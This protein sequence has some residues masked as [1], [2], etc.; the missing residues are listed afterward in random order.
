VFA[1]L[2]AL[3]GIEGRLF[4]PLGVA[5]LVSIF[6]SMVVSLTVT[7]V[8]SYYLLPGARATVRGDGPL[9]RAL[10]SAAVPVIRLSTHPRGLVVILSIVLIAVAGC[11]T[12][13][14]KMGKDFLPPFD[15]GAAQVNLFAASGTS[16]QTSREISRIADRQFSRL[17]RSEENPAGPLLWF[18][19]RTGRAEQ[20]EHVMG[21]HISEYVMT[22]NPQ[23]GLSRE[24]LIEK[25]HEATEDIPGVEVE[26]EQPIAHLISHMLSGVTA[27]IA[28]KLYGDDLDVL[29]S[30]AREIEAAVADVPGITPPVVEQQQIIPQL[31][32]ELKRDTLARYGVS[33]AFVQDFVETAMHGQ[34]VTEL[35]EGERRFDVLVRLAE[36]YR[37]DLENV[38]R[39]HFELPDGRRVALSELARVYRGGGPN[40]IQRDDGRRRIVIRVNTLGRDLASTVAEI[41][42]RVRHQVTL[43][44][45]YFIL[46]GGQFEAQ[47]TAS[48]RILSLSVVAMIVTFVVLY[49]TFPSTS[50]VLQ[51]LFAL[52][53]AFIGGVLALLMTGQTISVAAMVGFI[54]LGGIAARNGLLLVSTYLDL[55]PEEGFTRDMI[56]R[57]SLERLAPVL[58][59]ALTT[60]IALVP[61]VVGGHLPGKEILFPVATVILGGLISSTFCEFL[62]RPGLFWVFADGDA[63]RLVESRKAA[64]GG[65]ADQRDAF[66]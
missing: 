38:D 43:P 17:L 22:L 33:A 40:A 64:G 54:S 4:T 5:Y 47:Q 57:G 23:S 58:M 32:I 26:V 65:T 19:C 3:G 61:L 59:T 42:Q 53:A 56:I 60:G 18:T 36:P 30:K 12:V 7:P 52:P 48:R 1:P 24:E 25:L 66:Q 50:I 27:Q 34:V 15:E 55:L 45:G 21:V 41:Q 28:I 46:Y 35:Y 11:I 44:E 2:F 63:Q 62:V 29:R 31:R 20:D 9:L 8:L 37:K 10:K 39:L 51:I 13:V 16:L 14:L 49:S 6:A